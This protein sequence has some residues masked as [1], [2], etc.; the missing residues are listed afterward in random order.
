[1]LI[2]ARK[3]GEKIQIGEDIEICVVA[4]RGTK[5]RIGITAPASVTVLRDDLKNP[6]PP[7]HRRPESSEDAPLAS[8]TP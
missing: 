8:S 7:P 4:I 6:V 3:E 1:M 2:L 5:V